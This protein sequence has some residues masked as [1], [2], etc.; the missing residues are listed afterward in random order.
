M[1]LDARTVVIGV[2]KVVDGI[3]ERSTYFDPVHITR[4]EPFSRNSSN[5]NGRNR[6]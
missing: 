3:P 4:I 6:N 1:F 2:G 5:G